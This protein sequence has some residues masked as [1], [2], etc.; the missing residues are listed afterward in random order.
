MLTTK[1]VADLLRVNEETVR[2]WARS[3]ELQAVTLGS[4]IRFE[5]ADVR[6]FIRKGKK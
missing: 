4:V 1:E 3:G 2:R 5:E 6:A